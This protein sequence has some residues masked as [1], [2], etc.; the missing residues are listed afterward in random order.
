MGTLPPLATMPTWSKRL[1][2]RVV[3]HESASEGERQRAGFAC[4]GVGGASVHELSLEPLAITITI[5]YQRRPRHHRDPYMA[6]MTIIV[7]IIDIHR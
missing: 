7:I 1:Q 4:L 5:N 6:S 3:K 2:S